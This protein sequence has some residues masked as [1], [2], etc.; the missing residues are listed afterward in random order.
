MTPPR[1][2]YHT[3]LITGGGTGIG[4]GI[5]LALARRGCASVLVGR[6][7]EPLQEVS[8][9]LAALGV[10]GL[11]LRADLT[12]AEDRLALIERAHDLIGPIDLL[13]NNAGVLLG[14]EVAALSTEAIEQAM[15]VNLTAP[16]VL[17]RAALPDL[18]A[19]RGAVIFISSLIGYVPL[20]RRSIYAASKAGLRLFADALRY[21]VARH[22]VRVLVAAPPGTATAMTAASGTLAS[23][24]ARRGLYRLADPEA[25]GERIVAALAAG[26]DELVWSTVERPLLFLQRHAPALA[27]R[28]IHWQRPRL[29][30]MLG[31]EQGDGSRS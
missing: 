30:R 1:F 9:Q 2:P 11:P 16:L 10:R 29:A 5:A 14:G 8:Q 26:Q 13:V 12:A 25:V 24:F 28:L 3:A 21:E 4:R 20:P 17:T 6:R 18:I 7:P 31:G 23:Q 19:R 27:R 22:G 15:M